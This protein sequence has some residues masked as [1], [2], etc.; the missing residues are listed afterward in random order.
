MLKQGKIFPKQ[1]ESGSSLWCKVSL[2]VDATE[3][4]KPFR[5]HQHTGSGLACPHTFG[6]IC[7]VI[8]PYSV[9]FR[10]LHPSVI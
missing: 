9:A 10:L 5:M 2:H 7:L 8:L 1:L 6:H 4:H 3:C